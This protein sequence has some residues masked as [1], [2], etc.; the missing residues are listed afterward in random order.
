V[1]A[2]VDR[3]EAFER[4]ACSLPGELVVSVA[5]DGES[6]VLGSDRPFHA[7]S[8]IKVPVLAALLTIVHREAL[9]AGQHE[10]ATRAITESDNPAILELFVLLEGLAG[11]SAEAAGVIERLFRLSGDDRSTV[12]LPP[13]PPGAVTPFGQTGWSA[14]DSARFFA[15][16]AGERLLS[17]ADT[18]YVLDLMARIVPEQRWG[19][20]GLVGPVAFKGGWGPEAGGTCLV[21]Q[22]GVI[23]REGSGATAA[24]I[25]A[26]PPPGEDSFDA[27]VRIVSRAADWIAETILA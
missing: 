1:H 15:A 7:W 4:F 26:V 8:T 24:S 12:A 23:F 18:R 10:L 25:V 6:L 16:L 11:G 19:L 3:L 9:T 17:A 27:G 2:Q 20:G 13:P 22:S 5:L 21:R 14:A